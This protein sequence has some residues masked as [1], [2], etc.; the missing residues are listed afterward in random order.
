MRRLPFTHPVSLVA[1]VLG[2]AA[3]PLIVAAQQPGVLDAK[4]GRSPLNAGVGNAGVRDQGTQLMIIDVMDLELPGDES[5]DASEGSYYL[6]RTSRGHAVVFSGP[7]AGVG[8]QELFEPVRRDTPA[9][10]DAGVT[11]FLRGLGES[12]GPSLQLQIASTGAFRFSG[13]GVVVEPLL[14]RDA[15]RDELESRITALAAGSPVTRILNA[16]CLELLEE[17]PSL[18][19]IFRI[20]EAELQDLYKPAADILAASRDLIASGDLGDRPLDYI[21]SI[22]QWSLWAKEGDMDRSAFEDRFVEHARDNFTA[23]DV[24][25]TEESEREVRASVPERWAYID[26]ILVSAGSMNGDAAWP[27]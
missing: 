17:P 3:T 27:R 25:W 22:K 18:D 8:F 20:A 13:R 12:T 15:A 23:A 7:S 4:T 6:A 11:A 19:Q 21:H 10:Q 2:L 9:R 1:T 24:P 5:D 14:I 16:Y 26:R